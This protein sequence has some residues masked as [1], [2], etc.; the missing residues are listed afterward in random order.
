MKRLLHKNKC[1]NQWIACGW[2]ILLMLPQFAFAQSEVQL[3]GYLEHQYSL[4]YNQNQWTHLDYD[5]VRLDVSASAG[6]STRVAVAGVAQVFRGDTSTLLRDVLPDA[7]NVLVDSISIPIEDRY[8]LN[9]AYFT[10]RPGPVELTVGKQYLNWGAALAFNPTELFRPKNVLE[11]SYEREGV[12]ALTAR[13]ALG[14]LSDVMIGFVPDGNLADSGKLIRLRH[15]I[16]GYDIS[17]LVVS[18][19]E[20]VLPS[21]FRLFE[22]DEQRRITVGG[23][24]TGE[25]FGLGVWA[26]AT[27]S[28]LAGRQWVEAT[29]GSNYT[30]STGTTL[31][32]ESHYNGRG[33]WDTPYSPVLWAGRLTGTLR[34]MSKLI[35]YAAAAHPVDE[36][37]LWNVGLSG[38]VSAADGSAVLIPTLAYAFAQDVD[39]LFNGLIYVGPEDAEYAGGRY[40]GFL[41]GRVYF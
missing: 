20:A 21:T 33:T 29:V 27:W 15:H 24:M 23:D 2:L 37:Q 10:L 30:L 3:R 35:V 8:Y 18:L 5:R 13:L 1:T 34:S 25:L 22:L 16:A 12:G 40:G 9:H 19:T 11:P 17:A 28:D 38:I 26:E 6:R 36:Y 32:V 31:M 14:T 39:L 41:R 4:S 7:F